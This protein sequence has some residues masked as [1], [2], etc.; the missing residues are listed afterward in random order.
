MRNILFSNKIKDTSKILI[1]RSIS[2]RVRKVAPFLKYDKDP[3]LVVSEDGKL[4]WIQDA[5]TTTHMYP[6]SIPMLEEITEVMQ[7]GTQRGYRRRP[8]RTWGNYIRNSVK[9]VIDAYNGNMTYY[10][11]TKE[12]GQEDPIAE[13]Y[14]KMFPDLFADFK[15]M[16]D[17]LKNH[18]RYPLT[19][20]M[21]QA[22]K[23]TEYHLKDARQFYYKEDIWQV[24]TE[25]YQIQVESAADEQPV[26]PYYVILQLPDSPKEE[27]MLMLPFTPSSGKKNMVAWMAAKCDTGGN[28]DL[29]NYGELMVYNF[30]KGKLIDGTYQIEAYIDQK[31]EM[32]ERL[33]LWSQRGSN[34]LRG[35][36]LAI[37][38][39]ES[40]LYVEPIYIQGEQTA[41][42]PQLKRVVVAQ[43]G[44]LDWGEDLDSALAALYG[45]AVP[46]SSYADEIIPD[47]GTTEMYQDGTEKQA[48][49]HYNKAQEYLRAGE[50][51]KYGEEIKNLEKTLKMLQKSSP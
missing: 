51:A 35:N 22:D 13:C 40:M 7:Y 29:G 37:P 2:E 11:M 44:R 12:K 47:A 26:Q 23:Y 3:Y 50:W 5:Y 6:Y 42:I 9:V 16:P 15:D 25:K 17:Y 46:Q 39:K 18:V 43:D 36:M 34:V 24:A 30:P 27:F 31:E 14:R 49:G 32:S 8:Q 33:S 1:H 20:F 19:M 4:Y 48:L 38:I 10:L 28:G 21:I 41:A 45:R